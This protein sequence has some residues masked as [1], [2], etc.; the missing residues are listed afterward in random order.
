VSKH[1]AAECRRAI[2]RA[3]AAR[4]RADKAKSKATDDLAAWL[5][6]GAAADLSAREMQDL[7]GLSKQGYYVVRRRGK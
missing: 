3:A 1:T 5:S 4:E 6:H 2:K 7:A